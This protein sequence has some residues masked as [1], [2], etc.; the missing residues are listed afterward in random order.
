MLKNYY[1]ELN[2]N[3]NASNDE[4]LK[5][6]SL[7][8]RKWIQRQNAS[9]LEKR[10]LA[11]KKV[12]FIDEAILI[13]SDKAKRNEYDQRIKIAKTGQNQNDF[14][15]S[16]QTEMPVIPDNNF[17]EEKITIELENLF[18]SGN[19]EVVVN[20]CTSYIDKGYR[21][22]IIYKYLAQSY[23]SLGQLNMALATLKNGINATEESFHPYFQRLLAEIYLCEIKDYQQAKE[24]LDEAIKLDPNN[25]FGIALNVL[26]LLL[27]KNE[28]EA[29]EKVNSYL[30]LYPDDYNFRN[31]IAYA[32]IHYS[33][34]FLSITNKGISYWD[35]KN[36]YDSSLLWRE[37]ANEIAKSSQTNEALEKTKLYAKSKFNKDNLFGIIALGIVS[38]ILGQNDQILF[39]ILGFAITGTIV[40]FSIKPTW[41]IDKMTI[42]GKRDA[43]SWICK[44]IQWLVIIVGAFFGIIAKIMSS[45]S[46][47]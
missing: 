8:K 23:R 20:R 32:Y 22:P 19:D 26:Y 37:K 38:F 15:Q 9:D 16:S 34:S 41:E 30:T 7:Q 39:C 31:S 40:Y 6:L 3:T 36:A 24:Y 25:T 4:I 28:A 12:E 17:S 47:Y 42:T 33:D 5:D 46:R 18:D 44:G 43:V 35:N 27:T 14:A 45:S 13:F 21:F 2:L 29:I 10:Q 1:E 11:E